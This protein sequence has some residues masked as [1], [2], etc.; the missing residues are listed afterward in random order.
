MPKRRIYTPKEIEDCRQLYLEQNGQDILGLV[1]RMK[2]LGWKKFNYNLLYARQRKGRVVLGWPERFGWDKELRY[3]EL[4]REQNTERRLY[5][6]EFWLSSTFPEWS[7]SWKYQRYLFGRLHNVTTGKCRRLMIFLPPR[8]GKSELVTVRYTAW[9][10][11][12][13][14]KVNIILGSYNQ[15]L[16]RVG[17]LDDSEVLRRGLMRDVHEAA[18][19]FG[20]LQSHTL[21]AVAEVFDLEVARGLVKAMLVQDV[22]NDIV[23]IEQVLHRDFVVGG[24]GGLRRKVSRGEEITG[25]DGRA[26]PV[27]LAVLDRVEIRIDVVAGDIDRVSN[28]AGAVAAA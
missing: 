19:V 20:L 6:F 26:A 28:L 18:P 9:R 22:V 17:D 4:N 23:Q 25:R 12:E 21:A 27:R 2:D 3:R 15:R 1:K 10:M 14:A 11:I 16:A 8:H 13:D 7:W 24:R 5:D